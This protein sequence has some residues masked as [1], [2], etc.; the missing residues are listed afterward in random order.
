MKPFES[1][2]QVF[3]IV[4]KG[5]QSQ[6]FRQSRDPGVGCLYRHNDLKCA[7]GHLIPD[8]LYDQHMENQGFA[9]LCEAFPDVQQLIPTDELQNFTAKLQSI[10]DSNTN[11]KEMEHDLRILARQHDL[12]VPLP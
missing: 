1:I 7:A 8:D 4:F 11:P 6:Q 12:T 2:Q 9:D 3:A 5:L 10:H